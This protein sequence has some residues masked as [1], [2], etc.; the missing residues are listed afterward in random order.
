MYRRRIKGRVGEVRGMRKEMGEA[1]RDEGER[2]EWRGGRRGG[3]HLSCVS[4]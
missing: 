3:G 1:E 2:R 4:G